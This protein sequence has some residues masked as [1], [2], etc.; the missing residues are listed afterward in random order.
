MNRSQRKKIKETGGLVGPDGKP[1]MPGRKGHILIGMPT[2]HFDIPRATRES[3]NAAM[4]YLRER[5]YRVTLYQPDS[6]LVDKARNDCVE[7]ARELGA[8]WLM[9]IDSDMVFDPN[10]IEMLIEHNKDVVGGLCVKRVEPFFSTIYFHREEDDKYVPLDS[11]NP[12]AVVLNSLIPCDGTGSA[13]LLLKMSVFDRLEKPYYALPPAHW[14]EVV[15]AAREFVD[16]DGEVPIDRLKAAVGK[17]YEDN[18]FIGEDLFFCNQ[19]RFAGVE[20]FVDT[21]VLV[22]HVGEYPFTF[23][24]RLG[25]AEIHKNG[26]ERGATAAKTGVRSDSGAGISALLRATRKAEAVSSK[27]G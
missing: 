6:V 19:L 10:H 12:N 26:E 22:G 9:F 7:G 14:Y 18:G 16:G 11:A 23:I 5:G 8:D 15:R 27:P 21:G 17:S 3:T 4:R 20:V 1:I 25:Y 13:F 24:D 2:Y